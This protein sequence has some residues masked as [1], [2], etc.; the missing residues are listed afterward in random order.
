MGSYAG[1]TSSYYGR[2]EATP[3]TP[4]DIQQME[5]E[6][7]QEQMMQ[8][9]PDQDYLRERADAMEQHPERAEQGDSPSE[10]Q[11]RLPSAEDLGILPLPWCAGYE[12]RRTM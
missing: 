8:L 5:Q 4:W 9:I 2:Q 1:G 6:S 10:N 3:M 12:M 7:G 11:H